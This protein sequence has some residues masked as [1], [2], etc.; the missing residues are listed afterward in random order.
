MIE[1][2]N[3]RSCLELAELPPDKKQLYCTPSFGSRASTLQPIQ[4]AVALYA[5]TAVD[6]LRSQKGLVTTIHVFLHTSP[7]EHNYYSAS[8]TA[9]LPYPTDDVRLVASLARRTVAS[10]YKPGRE[11]VKA[12]IGLIEI[13]GRRHH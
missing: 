7:F 3:G 8:T 2:L 11:Y 6:K 13:Q 9:Q 12:G 10:L 4:K 5:S 1:E